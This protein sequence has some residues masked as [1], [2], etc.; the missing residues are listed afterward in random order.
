MRVLIVEDEPKAQVELEHML[1]EI[2]PGIQIVNKL[3]TVSETVGWLKEH[4]AQIDLIFLDIHLADANSFT[5][6]EQIEV[7]IP[8][9]F[10]TAYDEYA[11]KA[12][13]VNSID[14][15]LKPI[16]E[17]DLRISLQKYEKS[18]GKQSGESFDYKALVNA[19]DRS[20]NKFQSR[21]M[22]TSG[23]TIRS[24]LVEDIAYFRGEGKYLYI[25][26]KDNQKYI[27]DM[28]LVKLEKLLDP[29]RFFRINRK[30]I[31]S[32]EAITEMIAY[33]K[34]RVKLILK[35]EVADE[36]ETIVSVERS[37]N[38]KEWLNH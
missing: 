27:M 5:I 22:V 9:I 3:D 15:L 28:S 33:S 10:I 19:L 30:Y 8:I 4:G 29:K 34:S 23:A 18:V 2:R 1:T 14:Y 11:I 6:F 32:F 20:E 37:A 7:D 31:V 25:I 35:P 17:E 16:D 36:M 38:F 21:F 24:I 13:K 26:T 12:F